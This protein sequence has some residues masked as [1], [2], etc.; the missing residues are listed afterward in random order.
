MRSLSNLL[1]QSCEILEQSCEILEQS[2]EILEQSCGCVRLP[3][4]TSYFVCTCMSLTECW[5]S[6]KVI[7][8]P[9][10]VSAMNLTQVDPHRAILYG[11]RIKNG[12]SNKLFLFNLQTKVRESVNDIPYQNSTCQDTSY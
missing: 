1:E 6:P 9:S 10:P 3:H 2:C 5:I 8:R 7:N 12:R 4:V 11:G